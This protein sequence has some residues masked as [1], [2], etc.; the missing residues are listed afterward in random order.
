[1]LHSLGKLS[2]FD[3]IAADGGEAGSVHEVLFD[4]SWAVRFLF[5]QTKPAMGGKSVLVSTWAV[6]SVDAVTR[7]ILLKLTC[8]EIS[9]SPWVDPTEVKRSDT[10]SQS[11]RP[12]TPAPATI[13][14]PVPRGAG[15]RTRPK[16]DRR[17]R[18][19]RQGYA[20]GGRRSE[21]I[22][23]ADSQSPRADE[24]G[25]GASLSE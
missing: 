18:Q 2:G 25:G 23:D 7:T 16:P 8:D 12:S 3:V 10:G 22:E 13:A 17:Q 15:L 6:E 21:D 24:L 19:R 1:M 4:E 11:V 20:R 14:D 9:R 5:I